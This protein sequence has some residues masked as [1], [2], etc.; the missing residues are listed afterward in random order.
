MIE[1]TNASTKKIEAASDMISSI[2]DQTNLLAL[3]AAIEAARAGE[4]GKGFS[5]VADEI[6]KLAEDSAHFTKEIKDIIAELAKRAEFAVEAMSG[7]GKIVEEQKRSVD[8][9]NQQFEGIAK[10]IESTKN[11]IVQINEMQKNIESKKETVMS[12]RQL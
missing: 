1:S 9:T 6:R 12:S 10:A 7:V 3:N 2:A 5:V 4:A 11:I 8:D